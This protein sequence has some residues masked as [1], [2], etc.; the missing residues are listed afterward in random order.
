MEFSACSST[1]EVIEARRTGEVVTRSPG[2]LGSAQSPARRA[3]EGDLWG[4]T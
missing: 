3:Q 1:D 2:G 4:V